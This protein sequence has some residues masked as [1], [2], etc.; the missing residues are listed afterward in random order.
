[1]TIDDLLKREGMK[2]KDLAIKLDVSIS[3][4]SKIKNGVGPIT[5]R[6]YKILKEAYPNDSFEGGSVKWKSLYLSK[7]DE[8][9][10]LIDE[11]EQLKNQINFYKEKLRKI[12]EVAIDE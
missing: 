12:R 1:M 7:T 11:I 9:E 6:T 4:L 8:C 3:L 2:L 5:A 10:L